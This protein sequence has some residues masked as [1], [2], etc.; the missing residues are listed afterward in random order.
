[1]L[2]R[3]RGRLEGPEPGKPTLPV[4]MKSL[5]RMEIRYPL[6]P[7]DAPVRYLGDGLD[8]VPRRIPTATAT[9]ANLHKLLPGNWKPAT[10]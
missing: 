4:L 3:L 7:W 6:G 2:A 5:L 8:D 9:T 10:A 1:M